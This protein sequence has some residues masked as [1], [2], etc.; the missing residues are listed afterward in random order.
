MSGFELVLTLTL[1]MC[2]PPN[3][4]PECAE[5]GVVRGSGGKG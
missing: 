1:V 3:W 5:L 2:D 4:V